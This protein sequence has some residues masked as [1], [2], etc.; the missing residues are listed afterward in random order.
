MR[1]T[2]LL[3]PL[4]VIAGAVAAQAQPGAQPTKE[5]ESTGTAPKAD[6]RGTREEIRACGEAWFKDCLKD[7]DKGTHMSK[8]D[9]ARTCRR[10]VDNRVKAL[11]ED[12]QAEQKRTSAGH[13]P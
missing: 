10:V 6:C 13:R 9:Y 4:V 7:W 3:S 1:L 8:N 12:R 2:S 5:T 11:V